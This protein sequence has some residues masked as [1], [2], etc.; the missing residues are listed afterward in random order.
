MIVLGIFGIGY[1][2]LHWFLYYRSLRLSKATVLALSTSQL[3]SPIGG[4]ATKPRHIFIRWFVDSDIEDEA[5]V[6]NEWAISPTKS[7]YLVQ[8]ARPG[9]KGNVIIY[10]HNKREIL[11]NIRALKGSEI[12]TLTLE[13]GV[14]R[15]YAI[16]KLIEVDPFDTTYLKPTTTEVLTMYTCSGFLDSRRFI[17]RAVPVQ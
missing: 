9:E 13:N 4:P 7:S 5:L 6:H 14:Q 12:I 16:A 17:V 2:S 1:F 15:K 8:S 10:G 11:G 3:A